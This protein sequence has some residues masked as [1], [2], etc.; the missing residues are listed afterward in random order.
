[1][2]SFR[3]SA[4]LLA[5]TVS[6]SLALQVPAALAQASSSQQ[7]AQPAD[8]PQAS[9]QAGPQA[10]PQTTGPL[11]V[12]ARLKARREQRRAAAI[13]DVYS[14][15]YEVYVGAGYLR[16]TPGNGAVA[17]QGLQKVNEYAWNVGATRYYSQRLGVKLDG[18]GYY[19][20]AF[21]GPNAATNTAIFKPAISQYTA[22]AGPTYRFLTEPRYSVSG[23]IL[24]GG[25]F[26][27]FS[28]DLGRFTPA[29]LGLYSNGASVAIS[30]SVPVEYNLSPGIGLRVAP[31][32]VLTNF[33]S[34]IQNNVGFTGGVVVRWGKQ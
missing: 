9:S 30:A 31:E 15:L 28:G 13:H 10:A 22:M 1:M 5:L 8:A 27:N 33:G 21:I 19:G 20:S 3:R 34:T 23:R 2:F 16:F 26:G 12:Q 25:A 29:S 17:G 18:R 14:H 7:P 6:A 32:Y 11:T 24:A 4:L